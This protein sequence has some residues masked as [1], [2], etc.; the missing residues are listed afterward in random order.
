METAT[1]HLPARRYTVLDSLAIAGRCAPVAAFFYG[2]LDLAWAALTPVTTLVAARLIDAVMQT[3][4]GQAPLQDVYSSLALL[5]G[6]TAFGW[7]R[8]ALHNLADLRLV[9]ALRTRYRTALTAKRTR[10]EY[11]LLGQPETWD[12]IRRV[13][14]NP[15]GGRLKKTFYH[16]VDLAAFVLKVVGLLALLASAVWWAPLVVLAVGGLAL[17]TGVR[18][19]KALYQAER[20]VAEHDRRLDYLND[21]LL[22]RDAAAERTLFGAS[23]MVIGMLRTSFRAALG[24]RLSARWR[25]YVKAYAGNLTN[26]A[27]WVLLMLALLPSLQ[28]GAVSIGLFIALTQAFTRFDIV[29]G[30]MDTVNGLAADAEFFKDLTTFLALPE[31]APST[32]APSTAAPSTAAPGTAAPGIADAT[33][34]APVTLP[35]STSTLPP[36]GPARIE[37]RDVRFRYPGTGAALGPGLGPGGTSERTILDGLSLTLEAGKHYALVGANGCGKTTVTR[38]LTGLYAAESGCI[39][40]NGRDLKDINAAELRNL[41]SVVYQDFAR[42]S[43]SL[44]DNVFLGQEAT[45]D[46]QVF[47]RAGLGPLIARLPQGVDTPL[48]KLAGDGVDISGGEWQRVA[49]ARSLARPAA[50]RILDEPTAALDPVAESELYASFESLTGD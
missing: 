36:T 26:Q 29:W 16:L 6:L 49:M 20:Q 44:R 5:A 48:G 34:G 12:L 24:V 15:E 10:L 43:L 31:E 22:G 45:D 14:A 21:V 7:L 9:L 25:W 8:S 27:I 13:A 2:F 33:R 4:G 37:L 38:L 47:E 3:V 32:A 1:I 39:L 42:Y 40:V 46:G 11:A 28:T 50:L 23:S 30:F 35:A 19:G 41:I 18:S 17:I